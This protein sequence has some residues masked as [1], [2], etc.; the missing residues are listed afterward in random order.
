MRQDP[1]RESDLTHAAEA[2][3]P[4]AE[5]MTDAGVNDTSVIRGPAI[6]FQY[7]LAWMVRMMIFEPHA[8][9]FLNAIYIYF[10]VRW[11]VELRL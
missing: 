3:L 4:P 9:L 8:E 2:G 5:A 10:N 6:F 1:E 11:I 7:H